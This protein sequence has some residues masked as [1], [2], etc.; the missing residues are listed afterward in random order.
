[1]ARELCP[2]RIEMQGSERKNLITVHPYCQSVE[3]AFRL[4][5]LA[6]PDNVSSSTSHE[7]CLIDQDF[8]SCCSPGI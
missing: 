5:T 1:M 4:P 3:R 8:A 2:R 7:A 6:D